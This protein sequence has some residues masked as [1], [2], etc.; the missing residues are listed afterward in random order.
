MK[1]GRW[2]LGDQSVSTDREREALVQE[3]L[4]SLISVSSFQSAEEQRT[5]TPGGGVI[6]LARFE[7][8][9]FRT[10]HHRRRRPFPSHSEL[11]SMK[12]LILCARTGCSWKRLVTLATAVKQPYNAFIRSSAVYTYNVLVIRNEHLPHRIIIHRLSGSFSQRLKD[13]FFFRFF[14]SSNFDT[15][16]GN[17]CL[18]PVTSF[19]KRLRTISIVFCMHLLFQPFSY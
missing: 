15:L 4:R 19:R 11:V 17:A 6:N 8:R 7:I 1:K 9:R 13:D 3:T 10:I 14:S 2:S 18:L 16:R 5:A 12:D